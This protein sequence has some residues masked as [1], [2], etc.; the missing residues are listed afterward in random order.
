MFRI[1]VAPGA[2]RDIRKLEH[3]ISRQDFERL[4]LAIKNL[5]QEPRPQ[6]IRK[7]QGTERSYRVQRVGN[8]RVIYNVYDEENL[9]LIL[10]LGRRN[11]GTYR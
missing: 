10:Q 2:E 9:V 1:E 5:A 6:G 4:R 7:I 8:Y 3:R 11:E